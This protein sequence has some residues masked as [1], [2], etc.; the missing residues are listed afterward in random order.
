VT[1]A[2]PMIAGIVALAAGWEII[3]RLRLF[4]ALW[5]SLGDVLAYVAAPEHQ[6]VLGPA[7]LRTGGEALGGLIA[8]AIAAIV[9]AGI[10]V[11]IP[12][13]AA[14]LGAFAS[15]VNGIPIIAVAGVCML[16]LPRDATPIVVAAL[17]VG[18]IVF[19]AAT[20]A[21]A[22]ASAAHRDVFTVLGA[23][24]LTTFVRLDVPAAVPALVDGLRSAAPSAVVGAIVGEWF[25]A[26]SGLGPMLVAAMQNYAIAE[27]WA[28]AL[29]GTLL[30]IVFYGVLGGLRAAVTERFA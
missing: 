5:P 30:S 11:L 1:R 8:G 29:A 4:G 2:L 26:E 22:A 27:L 28:V 24:R 14:G 3:G 25:A 20:A 23:S 17:A 13:S 10:G 6:A 21:L 19:V 16:T 15:I 18:F 7:V 9:L 12:A